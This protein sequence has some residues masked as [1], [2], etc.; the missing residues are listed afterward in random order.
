MTIDK[1]EFYHGAALSKLFVSNRKITINECPS[2]SKCVYT[3]NDSVALYIKFSTGRMTRWRF[4]FQRTHQE[5]I[6]EIYELHK[7]LFLLLVCGSDG[8]VCLSYNE[9]K[10]VL[11]EQ[12]DDVEWVS[13]ER[14][15]KQQYRIKGTNGKLDFKIPLNAYPKKVFDTLDNVKDDKLLWIK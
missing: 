5:E 13:V 8:I 11:D 9:L 6:K 3:L 1:F 12:F 7:Q 10:K 14:W 2:T 15:R 4:S